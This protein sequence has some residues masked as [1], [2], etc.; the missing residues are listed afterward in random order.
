[1]TK[2]NE[3]P[4]ARLTRRK[5]LEATARWH[6]RKALDARRNCDDRELRRHSESA[7]RCRLRQR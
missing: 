5:I 2:P 1:M 7:M 4:E 3:D 6:E